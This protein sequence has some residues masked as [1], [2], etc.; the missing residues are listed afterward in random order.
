FDE[1]AHSIQ[2]RDV[3]NLDHNQLGR[4]TEIVGNGLSPSE[5]DGCSPVEVV[6]L[7]HDK[8]FGDLFPNA[9]VYGDKYNEY[10]LCLNEIL[11]CFPNSSFVFI[12][13]HPD[14]VAKSMLD[15]FSDRPWVPE[16]YSGAMSK[17][18]S[19]NQKWLNFR[20][21]IS[22]D[23]FVEIAYH[24]FLQDPLRT[25]SRVYDMLGLSTDT[26]ALSHAIASTAKKDS[27][28]SINS[29][30]AETSPEVFA[31]ARELGYELET[32]WSVGLCR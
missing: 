10:S 25:L 11:E 2:R 23:R 5:M 20:E 9:S 22:A 32:S 1:I 31:T 16:T 6:R 8:V 4:L 13:R 26:E 12:H 15:A 21:Q 30:G 19:W 3:A 17:W 27:R 7:L 14:S 29:L 28:P 18:A 24:Q